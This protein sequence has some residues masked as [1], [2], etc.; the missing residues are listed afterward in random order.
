[1]TKLYT[2][3][4]GLSQNFSKL[5]QFQVLISNYNWTF[6][7][8]VLKI[9]GKFMNIPQIFYGIVLTLPY[10]NSLDPEEMP[11][12]RIIPD[13]SCYIFTILNYFEAF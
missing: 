6:Q 3:L 13:P 9:N 5:F 12:W 10:A 4:Q 8:K 2:Y 1:M 11:T 7:F